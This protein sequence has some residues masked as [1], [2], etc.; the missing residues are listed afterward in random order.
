MI[1]IGACINRTGINSTVPLTKLHSLFS[2][3]HHSCEGLILG[4]GKLFYWS[5]RIL[6][7]LIMLTITYYSTNYRCTT[8]A[9]C[10]KGY[11]RDMC[12]LYHLAVFPIGVP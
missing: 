11:D 12:K 1:K 6:A 5:I 2:H 8:I 9:Q 3:P 10:Y 4:V 7:K